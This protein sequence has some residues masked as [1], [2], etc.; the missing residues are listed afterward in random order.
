MS[1]VAEHNIL[2]VIPTLNEEVTIGKQISDS[3]TKFH[4][5]NII[6]IDGG[7][8]DKTLE[9]ANGYGI[10]VIN[11][12]SK[13]KGNAIKEVMNGLD[14]DIDVL[15]FIDG[16]LTY[17]ILEIDKLLVPLIKEQADLVLGNRLKGEREKGSIS[18]FNIIGNWTFSILIKML[19]GG[20]LTDTQ[21]G[22][23]VLSKKC[24]AEITPHLKSE[25]FDIET[26]INILSLKKHLKIKSV[27][28]RYSNRPDNS[29]TKLNP[30]KVGWKILKRILGLKFAKL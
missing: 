4:K 13:G 24:I 11:Q 22:Y 17:D 25:S 8:T 1:L 26:E 30:I 12:S 15:V 27:P 5:D 3:L 16:D 10:K 20:E 21:T 6:L 28:I 19:Y 23:R 14:K 7:S 29:V 18:K 9:I 2:L